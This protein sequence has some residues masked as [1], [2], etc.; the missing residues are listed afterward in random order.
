M[1]RVVRPLRPLLAVVTAAALTACG[2]SAE[3]GGSGQES[4]PVRIM[5]ITVEENAAF[6]APQVAVAAKAQVD[7][8]NAAGGI[9]GRQVEL[10]VCDSKLD[11]NEE[12]GCFRRAVQEDVDAVVGSLS[13]FGAGLESLKDAAIPYVGGQGLA[14][15]ELVSPIS[16]PAD[17]GIPGLYLGMAA[18]LHEAGSTK[19]VVLASDTDASQ[20]AAA[21]VTDG[22]KR[23]G[24]SAHTV[25]VPLGQPDYS[26]QAQTIIDRKA[27]GVAL[28]VS[29]LAVPQVVKALRQAGYKGRIATQA[30][31]VND[32]NIEAL[33]PFAE[34]L[35]AV[36]T[37]SL[38]TNT[39][40]AGVADFVKRMQARQKD[41][42]IDEIGAHTWN[43]FDLFRAAVDR[44]DGDFSR[45][46]LLKVLTSVSDPIELPMA[47]SYRNKGVAAPL[48][49]YPRVF[50]LSAVSGRIADGK[51]VET[52]PVGDPLTRLAGKP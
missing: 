11:P 20:T 33:G 29:S 7:A 40:N 17:G 35:L 25:T 15:P 10:Q 42:R 32:S 6:S 27:D 36:S 41:V 19:P 4:D 49:D 28:A 3:S 13:F 51:L 52:L 43:G 22:F 26:A 1:K 16:F 18:T 48:A 44:V 12:A 37:V 23:V 5:T 34:G 30:S 14:A 38:P 2:G 39:E 24:T 8:L 9:D 45:E 46:R 50:N 47:G 31:G 21:V